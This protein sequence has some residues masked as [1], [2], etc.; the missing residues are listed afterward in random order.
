[1]HQ[2][3]RASLRPLS[4]VIGI[5]KS[6]NDFGRNCALD[7]LDLTVPH[8]EVHGF[9]D[10]K[11]VGKFITVPIL[12]GLLQPTAGIVRLLRGA[13]SSGC[14]SG[15]SDDRATGVAQAIVADRTGKQPTEAHMVPSSDHQ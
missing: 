2:L 13:N 12:L 10:P 8:A 1:M 15:N 14:F 6:V 11:G 4:D 7:G 9:L 3:L 5:R